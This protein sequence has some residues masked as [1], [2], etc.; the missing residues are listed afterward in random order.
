MLDT[1]FVYILYGTNQKYYREALISICSVLDK[2][3]SSNIIIL[4]ELVDF[5]P[6]H[7][8]LTIVPLDL[9]MKSK[10]ME[11]SDYHF[12]LK[13]AGLR[14]ILENHAKKIIFLDSD[15]IIKKDISSYFNHITESSFL[16]HK[17]EGKLSKQRHSRH[18]SQIFNKQFEHKDYGQILCTKN[19]SMYN[20]G[21]IGIC[22]KSLTLLNTALWLMEQI[23]PLISTH[24]AEQFSLGKTLSE[25]GEIITLGDNSVFH[26]WHKGPKNYI[27]D[28][29]NELLE[30]KS[31]EALL[32]SPEMANQ[33]KT[34]RH[35]SRWVQ[36]KIL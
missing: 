33:I 14:Y 3:K 10:W 34:K 12:K 19:C 27:H 7:P 28:Q 22:N 21:V 30:K 5:F 18:Y 31:K 24:T 8:R 16:M 4:S 13:L 29:S 23:V 20:S 26:Y 35:I 1:A 36:D 6:P 9:S 15:T 17:F 25:K 11:S 2:M 32:D